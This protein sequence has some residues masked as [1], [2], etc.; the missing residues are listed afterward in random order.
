MLEKTLFI[1]SQSVYQGH[2]MPS[3]IAVIS[4]SIK[5]LAI[6]VLAKME[7]HFADT[8]LKRMSETIIENEKA[9]KHAHIKIQHLREHLLKA[10]SL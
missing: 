9:N 1:E 5:D 6:A 3:A 8:C 4:S 10:C 7:T 2:V